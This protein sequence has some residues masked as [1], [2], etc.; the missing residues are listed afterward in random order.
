[1]PEDAVA[2]EASSPPA[3]AAPEE[4]QVEDAGNEL[5]LEEQLAA[6][7]VEQAE[8]TTS[9]APDEASASEDTAEDVPSDDP[10]LAR[11][12][13]AGL[14]VNKYKTGEDAVKGLIEGYN[15]LGERDE[16]AKL[17]EEYLHLQQAPQF[18]QAVS[19]MQQQSAQ[20][21]AGPGGWSPPPWTD[22][23]ERMLLAEAKSQGASINSLE[24]LQQ[25]NSPLARKYLDHSTYTEG[26]WR[27]KM[28]DTNAFL[29]FV[30][31]G[32]QPHLQQLAVNQAEADKLSGYLTENQ[33]D[34]DNDAFSLIS[35]RP[36]E[37]T[38]ELAR[39]RKELAQL[40]GQ[41]DD[42]ESRESAVKAVAADSKKA[43]GRGK[44]GKSA[45]SRLAEIKPSLDLEDMARAAAATLK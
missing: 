20:P 40:K 32:L 8:E 18:Q 2:T 30:W 44:S 4:A 5:S 21:Q 33:E 27:T 34:W 1:M 11:L 38:I 6:A 41:A 19:L 3:E 37:A 23:D 39:V 26:F 15:K 10:V 7:A 12:V 14:P 42:V 22:N 13:D 9:E 43:A 35:Q 45:D 17:G 16:M 36:A 29:Q 31:D 24:D 25:L 28:K